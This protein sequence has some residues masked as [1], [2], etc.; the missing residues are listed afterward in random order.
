MKLLWD[1]VTYPL[2]RRL[3]DLLGRLGY[4]SDRVFGKFLKEGPSFEMMICRRVA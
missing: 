1:R 3:P 4:W 2:I